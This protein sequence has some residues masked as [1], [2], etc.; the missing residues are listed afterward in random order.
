MFHLIF[1]VDFTS[2]GWK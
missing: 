2:I 1:M